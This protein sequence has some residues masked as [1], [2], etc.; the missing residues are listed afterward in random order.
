MVAV[1]KPPTP[2]VTA[3]DLLAMPSDDLVRRELWRGVL[4]AMSPAG[5]PHP[6][7]GLRLLRALDAAATASGVGEMWAFDAGY[8]LT[9]APDT[10]VAPDL[11][12][13]PAAYAANITVDSEG[14]HQ[15]IPP[16]VIEIKSPSDRE[17]QIAA[18]L[19]LYFECGVPEIWWV[20]PKQRTITRHWPD[21]DPVVL[22]SNDILTDVEAIPGVSIALAELFPSPAK[23]P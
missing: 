23:T 4:V 11:A 21:R 7:I 14:F 19:A 1:A 15:V 17:G 10:V 16:L 8:R 13:V 3:D 2:L 18:K 9:T 20:R 22:G 5:G 12:L 6:S